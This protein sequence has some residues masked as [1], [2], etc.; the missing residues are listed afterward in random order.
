MI[1][2]IL[3]DSFLY[4]LAN[5]FTKGIGF[6]MIPI[7]TSYFS[8]KEYG[9]IDLLVIT[10]SLLSIIIGLEIHQAVARFFPDAKNENEKKEIVSSALWSIIFLYIIFFILT[11]PFLEYISNYAFGSIKYTNTLIVALLS[12][13]FNFIYFYVSA[14][15]RWQLKSKQNVIVSFI[16]SLITAILTFILL[17]YF[18]LGINSVFVS[19]II[20]ATIGIILSYLYS[21]EYYG[22]VFKFEKLKSLLVFSTPLIFSSILVYAMLYI[23]RVMI[24]YFLSTEDVGLYGIAFR[25]ASITTLLTVGIQT[26]LTPLIY[27]NY[28][29]SDTPISI[30]KLFHYFILVGAI[31][32]SSLFIFSKDIVLLF[33]NIN[34]I[35]SYPII[36][37]LAISIIFSGIVNFAPGLFIAKKTKYMLYINIFAFVLNIVL[38]FILINNFGLLGAAY[39]TVISNLIYF[40]FYY[41]MGQKYYF[42]PYIWTKFNFKKGMII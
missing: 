42:I 19:Q 34:Y 30:A 20:A 6:I 22:F 18:Y 23:D 29:N 4:T 31:F 28:E 11:M 8:T 15:L 26:A 2:N 24:N 40:L 5:L 16:Y 1:K 41:F 35:D 39:S 9:I 36:P 10:G 12:F 14:Q 32:V 33:A 21:K 7:Y 37:W 27:N 13:G 38:N 3:K 17:K 25:F